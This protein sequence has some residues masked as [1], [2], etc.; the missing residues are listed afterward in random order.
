MSHTLDFAQFAYGDGLF[1]QISLFNLA[2]TTDANAVLMARDEE[3]EPFSVQLEDLQGA[4]LEGSIPANGGRVY[5]TLAQG[6]ILA[7]S[8]RVESDQ[9]LAGVPPGRAM[10][11]G[12]RTFIY[13]DNPSGINTG[14]AIVNLENQVISLEPRLFHPGGEPPCG[15]ARHRPGHPD[16]CSRTAP[17]FRDGLRLD[18]GQSQSLLRNPRARRLGAIRGYRRPDSPGQFAV[19][20]VA[21]LLE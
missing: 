16:S 21:R 6:P 5:Q 7:G 14:I 19:L 18:T 12:F 8:L 15:R 17:L 3:G 4:T 2:G 13:I 1:S 20:P 10:E 9:P 11:S